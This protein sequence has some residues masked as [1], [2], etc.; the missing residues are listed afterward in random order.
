M[1]TVNESDNEALSILNQEDNLSQS[2]K[3]EQ[4]T[5]DS[6]LTDSTTANSKFDIGLYVTGNIPV[7]KEFR[8]EILF[9]CWIP[10]ENYKF[11]PI[12][13]GGRNRY[14]NIDCCV[15]CETFKR[16]AETPG[17][18]IQDQLHQQRIEQKRLNRQRLVPIIET[19]LFLGRQEL[20][21]R[22]HRGESRQLDI[23][24][25]KENDG[26]FRAALRLRLRAGD[27]VLK[28]H[29]DSSASNSKYLSP[30]IQNEI[31]NISGTLICQRIVSEVQKS[32]PFSILAD[33]SAD[34]SAHEQ[35]SI[36][37]RY[38]F[39]NDRSVFLKEMFLG[40]IIV[41]DLTGEG[42]ANSIISFCIS[43]GL[44]LNNLVGLGLD[45][46]SAMSGKYKGVQACI[47]EKYPVVHYTHCSSH[48][49][50]LAIG[51]ANNVVLGNVF[52][53]LSSIISF[54]HGYPFREEKLRQAIQAVCPESK[55][56]RLKTICATRWVERHDAML[57]FMELIEAV[58]ACLEELTLVPGETG[59]KANQL[60]HVCT[61]FDF[62]YSCTVLENPSALF[63]TVSKQLQ[64]PTKDLAEICS[65]IENVV[66]ILE[67]E[68][69]Q[70]SA[71]TRVYTKAKSISETF[72]S[73]V[74]LPRAHARNNP[75]FVGKEE[76]FYRKRVFIPYY[77]WLIEQMNLR[78]L[79]HKEK[80]FTLQKLLPSQGGKMPLDELQK[81]IEPMHSLMPFSFSEIEAQIK[82]WEQIWIE[83]KRKGEPIPKNAMQWIFDSLSL[84][85]YNKDLIPAIF[86][87]L[88]IFST[89]PITT[90][91][92]K[93]SFSTLKRI[94]IYLRNSKG[95]E[96]LTGLAIISVHGREIQLQPEKNINEMSK[97]IRKID[98]VL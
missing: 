45:G 10:P 66:S 43:T 3:S 59:S 19:I 58:V 60:V 29:L 13:Q 92:S 67:K 84:V 34:V 7:E 27:I 21:F 63:L 36:S 83:K 62:I 90:A 61:S 14:F 16:M 78:F 12:I 5:I 11:P 32:V 17:L 25:P 69:N 2:E 4:V 39:R 47:R 85:H 75:E 23:E 98:F 41:T 80:V 40:F 74:T 95:E 46:A 18:D 55:R 31:I 49:L 72:G 50:N 57:V 38:V 28:H 35:L 20:S 87:I 96:R 51:K 24:E 64:S 89:I 22:G 71:I 82:I 56:Q 88:Q 65:L 73:S 97:S 81:V 15:D 52:S 79:N 42:I 26:N 86:R 48:S 68:M 33:E 94:K 9:N 6:V 91:T 8:L 44:D 93:R 76:L 53:N 77:Q 70:D 54:F 30:M 1:S 37:V